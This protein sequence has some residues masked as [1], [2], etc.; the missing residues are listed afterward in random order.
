MAVPLQQPSAMEV[1]SHDPPIPDLLQG[2]LHY[3]AVHAQLICLHPQCR[4]ALGSTR[5]DRHFGQTHEYNAILRQQLKD[6]TRLLP[7]GWGNQYPDLTLLDGSPA[8]PHLNIRSGFRC[9]D[10]RYVTVDLKRMRSH[11]KKDRGASVPRHSHVTAML[12]S[13]HPSRNLWWWVTPANGA[14]LASNAE[15]DT[16][17]AESDAEAAGR[18][19]LRRSTDLLENRLLAYAAKSNADYTAALHREEPGTRD[20]SPW[21]NF[22]SWPTTFASASSTKTE[23]AELAALPRPDIAGEEYMEQLTRSLERIVAHTLEQQVRAT[24]VDAL[25][26]LHSPRISEHAHKPWGGPQEPKTRATYIR[27]YSRFLAYLCRVLP[28]AEAG[29]P[30]SADADDCNEE[31]RGDDDPWVQLAERIGLESMSSVMFMAG[32]DMR[33]AAQELEELVG[34]A[35]KSEH[36]FREEHARQLRKRQEKLRWRANRNGTPPEDSSDDAGDLSSSD[37]GFAELEAEDLAHEAQRDPPGLSALMSKIQ[38]RRALFEQQLDEA[39]DAVGQAAITYELECRKPSECSVLH[40]LAVMGINPEQGTFKTPHH[41]T[42]FLAGV[43]WMHRLWTLRRAW[44]HLA[45]QKQQVKAGALARPRLMSD[46]LGSYARRFVTDACNRPTARVLQQLA[47]GKTIVREQGGG[48]T[49]TWDDD[50][51]TLVFAGRPITVAQVR[52]MTM[53]LLATCED[54]LRWLMLGDETPVDI[55]EVQDSLAAIG[56]LEP[57]GYSMLSRTPVLGTRKPGAVHLMKRSFLAKLAE[58]RLANLAEG[59]QVAWAEQRCAT[60]IA[61]EQAFLRHL[62]CAVHLTGGLPSRGAVLLN[63]RA[64]SGPAGPRHLFVLSQSVAIITSYNKT[65]QLSDREQYIARH[66]PP[67]LGQIVL[68]YMAWVRPFA[69]SMDASKRTDLRLF[70]GENGPW[71]SEVVLR[72]WTEQTQ[73]AMGT[74]LTVADWRHVAIALGRRKMSK[75]HFRAYKVDTEWAED[76][77]DG[78][79]E[80]LADA[81]SGHTTATARAV[82][83]RT[84]NAFL[85]GLHSASLAGFR[86]VS[87]AWHRVVMGDRA[88]EGGPG[89]RGGAADKLGNLVA[90]DKRLMLACNSPTSSSTPALNS[91]PCVS[92]QRDGARTYGCISGNGGSAVLGS[93][94]APNSS[95][96]S[97]WPCRSSSAGALKDEPADIERRLASIIKGLYGEAATYRSG[98]QADAMES[99]LYAG[100]DLPVVVVLGTSGGKSLMFMGMAQLHPHNVTIVV[101]PFTALIVDVIA[102]AKQLGVEAAQWLPGSPGRAPLLIVS[103]D[104]AVSDRFMAHAHELHGQRQLRAVFLDEC[105]VSVTD[106]SYRP[107]LRALH[108]LRTLSVPMILLTA[109]L[110]PSMEGDLAKALS[111]SDWHMRRYSTD[112]RLTAHSLVQ[113]GKS[114]TI[115]TAVIALAREEMAEFLP[116]QHKG[117]IYVGRKDLGHQLAEGLGCHMYSADLTAD[118]QAAVLSTWQSDSG[119]FLVATSALGTGVDVKGVVCIIHAGRPQGLVA[120]LQQSGRGGRAG[121]VVRSIIVCGAQDQPGFGYEST[122]AHSHRRQTEEA[123]TAFLQTTKCR[124][125]ILT[126]FAD[127]Q[128]R[129]CTDAEC[130]QCDLCA[131]RTKANLDQQS[132]ERSNPLAK[133]LHATARDRMEG[134]VVLASKPQASSPMGWTSHI[135]STPTPWSLDDHENQSPG[136]THAPLSLELSISPPPKRHCTSERVTAGAKPRSLGRAEAAFKPRSTLSQ[137]S[138]GSAPHQSPLKSAPLKPAACT[139]GAPPQ[140]GRASWGGGRIEEHRQPSGRAEVQRKQSNVGTSNS[141]TRKVLELFQRHCVSCVMQ[142]KGGDARGPAHT[143]LAC[144]EAAGKALA[145]RRYEMKSALKFPSGQGVCYKCCCPQG[146]LWCEWKPMGGPYTPCEFETTVHAALSLLWDH[147][148]LGAKGLQRAGL[149]PPILDKIGRRGELAAYGKWLSPHDEES[150]ERGATIAWRVFQTVFVPLAICKGAEHLA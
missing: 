117:V 121:E 39:V 67:R 31:Q 140:S 142:G 22:V 112:R 1:A 129:L 150:T 53:Q 58:W 108:S 74:R 86:D 64:L 103:A 25:R 136:P 149:P 32:L 60:Y 56:G 123:L 4:R 82:Y 84:A 7:H 114:T 125:A 148:A 55:N 78:A 75:D 79:N 30:P 147:P 33:R 106:R 66:L 35:N 144:K 69:R 137:H 104:L 99:V 135:P 76:E 73:A 34:A 6:F 27:H 72:A 42:P 49:V 14:E 15:S 143:L 145:T 102:R 59:G 90:D 5:T 111:I 95:G 52:H 115:Q 11:C 97:P 10:C 2:L 94:F 63:T 88:T 134:R 37:D 110:P 98:D 124:R 89:R 116:G 48:V 132:R 54:E 100:A 101:L 141:K 20:F 68:R 41:Y 93:P 65:Q 26:W 131:S 70:A 57:V 120:Y 126:D 128:A 85:R 91:S 29:P 107:A 40:W 44:S 47:Y 28:P 133:A 21:L 138:G 13:W 46:L 127:G 146:G 50:G 23:L 17:N 87:L 109:T 45:V 16:E 51:E 119:R 8:H 3:D 77:E 19:G 61:R 80:E 12:Q 43:L 139:W 38:A 9:S 92:S 96:S 118:E 24:P 71:T 113:P 81:Q 36:D 83:A 105:H 122:G 62:M 18:A 130:A